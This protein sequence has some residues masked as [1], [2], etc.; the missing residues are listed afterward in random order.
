MPTTAGGD[1]SLVKLDI[2]GKAEASDP[3]AR[4]RTEPMPA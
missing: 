2:L 4:G 1:R 3:V